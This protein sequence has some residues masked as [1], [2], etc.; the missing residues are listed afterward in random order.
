MGNL[1]NIKIVLY[2]DAS[3][4]N[5]SDGIS[6][7]GG[8]IVFLEGENENCCPISWNT[9]KIRRVVKSTI[10]AEALSLVDGLDTAFYVGSIVTE[11]LYRN[12]DCNKIPINCYIDN[13]SLYENLHSTKSVSEKRLRI[14][15]AAVKEMMQKG[16]IS[17][18]NWIE[19]SYQLSDCFTKK[20]ASSKK[21]IN[22][23]KSG[24]LPVLK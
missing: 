21:L 15:I 13:H 5:L 17:D 2:S 10:A 24:Q 11:I 8:H 14:D 3:Y 9:K 18:V 22:V 16:E 1:A 12:A 4:A 20:G 19:A 6:S 23:L 7:A